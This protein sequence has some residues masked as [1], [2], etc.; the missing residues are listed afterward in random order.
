MIHKFASSCSIMKAL[1]GL[2]EYR[3]QLRLEHN[4]A[5]MKWYAYYAGREQR[6]LHDKDIDWE[7]ASDTPDEAIVKLQKLIKRRGRYEL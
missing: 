4:H 6:N 7:T 3:Y 1:D 2:T 5:D